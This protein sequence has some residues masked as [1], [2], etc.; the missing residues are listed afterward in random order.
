MSCDAAPILHALQEQAALS[1]EP[2]ALGRSVVHALKAALPQ[3]SWVGIYWLEE[4]E[5]V[6]GP[7]EGPPTEHVR[8]PVGR[9]VCGR[10]VEEDSDRRIDDVRTVQEYL[11]C[12]P[13]VRSEA[14]VL[15]R[16]QGRI[17]GQLDLDA[18]EVGA[19]SDDDLCVLRTVADAF[20]ALIE[21]SASAP[22]SREGTPE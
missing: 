18:E 4:R 16:S 21:P 6:L 12:S 11:A 20:G 14:V 5:L 17:V 2:D 3:A 19:F 9:G 15:I 7:F 13:T 22:V 1:L 8:I 10:A